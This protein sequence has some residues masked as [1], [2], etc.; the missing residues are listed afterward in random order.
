MNHSQKYLTQTLIAGAILALIAITG[1][2]SYYK[3]QTKNLS[4]ET[5]TFTSDKFG[6]SLRAP[7]DYTVSETESGGYFNEKILYTVEVRLPSHY[8]PE[9]DFNLG[10]LS[11]SVSPTTT[12][13]YKDESHN[14]DMTTSRMINGI[15][16]YYNPKQPFPDAAMGGQRGFD[17]FYATIHNN[18]CIR[19]EKLIGY[20]DLRGF[21]EPPYPKHFDEKQADADLEAVISTI[22]LKKM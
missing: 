5:K 19:I 10:F 2:Y 4:A 12:H 13:C 6:I 14:V 3:N 9:T 1:L 20:R 8:Q 15:S 17:S 18:Q 16:F 21:A 7:E 22:T 11:I